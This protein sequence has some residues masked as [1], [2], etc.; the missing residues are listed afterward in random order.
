MSLPRDSATEDIKYYKRDFWSTENLK[1]S[2]PHYRMRKSARIVN[3]IAQH[4]ACELLDVGCGPA[5]LRRLI[6]GDISYHGVDIAIQEPAPY[7]LEYDFLE[8]P[9]S[10]NDMSFD[11][12]LAQ[13]VFEYIGAFQDQKFAEISRLLK[14]DGHFVVSYV[15]F[16]HRAR[17]IY[18]PYSNVQS[19]SEF[20]DS[21]AAHF[22]IERYFPTSHNWNHSEPNRPYLQAVQLPMTLSV[23]VL[24]RYLAVEYFFICSRA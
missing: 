1:F 21:L 24:S 20:R 19:L 6:R 23:P 3:K 15:N 16:D 11:I 2:T 18:W 8:T 4:T 13:G 22:R 17:K 9:I 10:F 14:A 12:V 7:L 5:T